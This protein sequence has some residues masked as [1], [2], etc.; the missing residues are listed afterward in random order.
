MYRAIIMPMLALISLLALGTFVMFYHP[1]SNVGAVR[2]ERM[3]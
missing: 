1:E 2:V 3:K